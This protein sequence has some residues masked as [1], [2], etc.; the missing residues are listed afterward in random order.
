MDLITLIGAIGGQ[1]C[2]MALEQGHRLSLIVR[3]STKLPVKILQNQRVEVIEG[4]LDNETVLDQAS[5]CGADVFVSL[6]G[7]PI[8]TTGT[9]TCPFRA[10]YPTQNA[11]IKA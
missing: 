6:A 1:F 4:T 2:D 9:V 10:L 7:P 8:G 11:N 5:R 3:N